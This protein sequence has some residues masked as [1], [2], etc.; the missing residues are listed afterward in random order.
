VIA[1]PA[2]PVVSD[3]SILLAGLAPL[4]LLLLLALVYDARRRCVPNLLA[5]GGAAFALLLHTLLPD[6]LGFATRAPGALGAGTALAGLL[7][8]VATFLPLYLMRVAGPGDVKL[9]GMIGAFLGPADAVGVVLLTF[10]FGAL[11]TIAVPVAASRIA[12][13][14]H[15]ARGSRT[16]RADTDIDPPERVSYVM[17]IALATTGWLLLRS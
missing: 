12:R 2:D 7:T 13:F 17:A 10:L 14:A 5:Y 1:L 15:D 9:V 3:S 11:L 4:A 8:G 6:G 16:A